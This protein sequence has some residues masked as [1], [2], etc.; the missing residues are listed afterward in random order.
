M[1]YSDRN[2]NLLTK[3]TFKTCMTS[4]VTACKNTTKFELN[5]SQFTEHTPYCITLHLFR[6]K[7]FSII[8]IIIIIIIIDC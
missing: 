4:Q 7:C 5:Q 1:K 2:I 8:I 3:Y 6:L